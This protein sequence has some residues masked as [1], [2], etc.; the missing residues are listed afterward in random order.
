MEALLYKICDEG[1]NRLIKTGYAE[2]PRR[3]R[4]TKTEVIKGIE[5]FLLNNNLKGILEENGNVMTLGDGID[6]AIL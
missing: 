6:K 5:R 4:I 3:S 1:L 2:D